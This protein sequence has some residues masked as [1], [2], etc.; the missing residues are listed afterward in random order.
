MDKVHVICD[1]PSFLKG[2]T[3]FETSKN[4]NLKSV[5]G[6]LSKAAKLKWEYVVQRK[7]ENKMQISPARYLRENIRKDIVASFF[8]TDL[9][10][11]DLT[12]NLWDFQ[13]SL[14]MNHNAYA[15][16]R[17]KFPIAEFRQTLIKV[18]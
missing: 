9:D 8:Q 2:V 17:L 7:N 1:K 12:M 5:E 16:G 3:N 4:Q 14:P 10:D 6:T 15:E 13:C 11:D 18:H